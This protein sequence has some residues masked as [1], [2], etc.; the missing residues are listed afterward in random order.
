M[1]SLIAV[2]LVPALFTGAAD[3]KPCVKHPVKAEE[4]QVSKAKCLK[5]H[6]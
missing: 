4:G 5:A 3:A 6:K 2:V 1:K